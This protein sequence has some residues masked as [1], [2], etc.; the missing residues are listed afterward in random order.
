MNKSMVRYLLSKL[1]L[2]EA[3]LL[4]VPL[5]VAALY[6]EESAVFLSILA[7]MGL[8]FL[9]GGLGVLIKPKNYRIY[10]KEALLIVAL[11][12]VLW[13]FFG[14]LPFVF[15]GQIPNLID[16][17][18]ETSSGFTT[19]GATI[20]ADTAVLSPALMF[21]RSFAHLIGGMGV[22][23][24]ALAIMENSKNSHLEVMRAEVP[25]P[26]F[27]K[28]V[29]KLKDTAQILYIIYLAMF[30][31]F[32]L[33]LWLAGLPFYDSLITA[34]GTA[35]TGGFAVYNDSIAHYD[36]SLITN[37]VSLGML[38]FG[39]NFNLYYFLLL[40][41]FKVFFKDEE[42]HTY[43]KIVLV[44]AGLIAF[45]VL[46]LYDNV[47]Q[48]LEYVFFQVSATITTTGYGITDISGWPL[49]SQI[50]LLLLMFVGGSAGSTA[51]GFKVMRSLILTKI[52]KNQVLSTLYP[53]RMMSLHI[54]HETIDKETQHGVLKYLTLYVIFLLGL[55]FFLSLD[56]N[57]FMTVFSAAASCMN[58]IGPMLGTTDNFAI[59]SPFSKVL[60][61]FAMIAGR[62]EIY[63]MLLFFI[64]KTW[65]KI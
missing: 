58:N 13:S 12:W 5:I 3:A 37:L 42:L 35:G 59:F 48:G 57:N 11:C 56:N 29:S 64:P 51:G 15:T 17:F 2:I 9:L 21:W 41:K 63:P 26:V 16:A 28:M 46:G 47:R 61:S 10:T 19:T 23:V 18:F 38:A 1:L 40:R 24:F 49:F 7:T 31:V 39:V 53:N 27:G 33:I 4:I 32:T 60:L 44:A 8:L 43:I 30:A 6:R 55:V 45:N 65:S 25:G 54:N 20:L 50:I 52:T 36:S 22:L 62:L 34:M 14:A